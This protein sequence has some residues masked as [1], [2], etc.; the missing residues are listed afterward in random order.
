MVLREAEHTSL[1]KS[2]GM[3]AF[4]PAGLTVIALRTRCRAVRAHGL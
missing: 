3:K 4:P 1:V 2:S